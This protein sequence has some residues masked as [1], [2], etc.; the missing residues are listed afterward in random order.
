MGRCPV[1]P[2]TPKG[3]QTRQ[4]LNRSSLHAWTQEENANDAPAVRI[5]GRC[6]D[7]TKDVMVKADTKREELTEEISRRLGDTKKRYT[8]EVRD[9]SGAKQQEF[10]IV[11][12]RT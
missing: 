3:N 6:G 1:Q 4:L 12:G 5:T 11:E 7:R 8:M 10:R 2:S 9:K